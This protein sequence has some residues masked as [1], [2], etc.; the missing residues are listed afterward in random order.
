MENEIT[1]FVNGLLSSNSQLNVSCSAF[2]ALYRK[3]SFNFEKCIRMMPQTDP[4]WSAWKLYFD[5]THVHYPVTTVNQRYY[6]TIIYWRC[7]SPWNQLVLGLSINKQKIPL[8]RISSH[9]GG[10]TTHT[11]GDFVITQRGLRKRSLWIFEYFICEYYIDW[12]ILKIIYKYL[13]CIYTLQLTCGA[14]IVLF[15]FL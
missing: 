5:C 4:K 14:L 11:D 1:T 10:N 15:F 6:T 9:S 7:V 2:I 8:C 13:R 3:T 12:E